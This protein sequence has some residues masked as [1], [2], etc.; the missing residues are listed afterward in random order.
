[1]KSITPSSP[2]ERGAQL[3][4]SVHG[5]GKAL[6]DAFQNRCSCRL[7]RSNVIR[8]APA[9]LYNSFEDCYWFGVFLE[10]AIN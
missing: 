9:P 6:F 4:I 1:M 8:I 10:K 3:S 2:K 7:A 5:K